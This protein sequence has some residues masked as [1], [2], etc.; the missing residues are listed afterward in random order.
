MENQLTELKV[1][2]DQ[3]TQRLE[4]NTLT[5]PSKGIV[6]LNKGMKVMNRIPTGTEIAQNI[7]CHHRYKR[8]TNHYYVSSGIS[9]LTR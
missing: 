7:P 1:Q 2:L 8:S 9:P 5:A 6:H 3:A 4:N